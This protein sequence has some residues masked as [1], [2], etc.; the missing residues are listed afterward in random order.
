MRPNVGPD[1][2]E[3]TDQVYFVVYGRG[4]AVVGHDWISIEDQ[5]MVFV[6]AGTRR[7]IRAA[8][9][10]ALKL[11]AVVAAPFH[12]RGSSETTRFR[13]REKVGR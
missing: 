11:Y 3:N 1:T 5:D 2:L 9:D 6:H 7:N 13:T 10:Q 12:A 4:E 8:A